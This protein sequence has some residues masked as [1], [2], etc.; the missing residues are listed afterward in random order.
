MPRCASSDISGVMGTP[1]PVSKFFAKPDRIH[2]LMVD[3][4]VRLCHLVR[5]YLS[6]NGFDVSFVHSG[7]EGLATAAEGVWDVVVL[8]LR[9][10]GMDGLE[11]LRRLRAVSDVPV[12][13]LTGL[14]DQTDRIVGPEIGADDYLANTFSMQELLARLRAVLRRGQREGE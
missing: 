8:D 3:D 5:D 1:V 11:V 6:P 13:M 4:D 14:G 12:L 10:P 7:P 2:L 9:L